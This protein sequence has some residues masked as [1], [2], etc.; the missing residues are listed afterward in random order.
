MSRMISLFR[1]YRHARG[2]VGSM[3]VRAPLL[4]FALTLTATTAPQLAHAQAAAGAQWTTPSGTLQGTRYSS[5]AQI[6]S[7]N[8]G[9]LVEEFSFPT[10]AKASHEGQPLIVGNTMY[11]VTPFPHKLIALDLRTPGKVLWTFNPDADEFAQGVACCDVV[12][13]GAAYANGKIIYNVL[14]DTTVAVAKA[15]Q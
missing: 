6:T 5:L 3:R 10:G 7:A 4:A 13:R 2:R 15:R 1:C 8:V 12:N 9:T 11:I 14:D